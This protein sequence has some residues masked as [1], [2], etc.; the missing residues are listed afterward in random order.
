MTRLDRF[1]NKNEDF[2]KRFLSENEYKEFKKITSEDLKSKF[3]ATRWAIKEAIF[4]ADNSY[5][6]FRKVDILKE[7][8]GRY[9]FKDFKISTSDEGNILVAVAV[10]N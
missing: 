8:C 3:L 7:E 10:K 9:F 4:K 6:D 5:P 2:V 1:K